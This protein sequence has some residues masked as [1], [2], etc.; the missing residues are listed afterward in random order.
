MVLFLVGTLK[1]REY[2]DRIKKPLSREPDNL[3]Y[4]IFYYMDELQK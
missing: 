3:I 2:L 1:C 4:G